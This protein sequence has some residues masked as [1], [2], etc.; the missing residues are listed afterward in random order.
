MY[1]TSPKHQKN[2]KL[3]Q[4]GTTNEGRPLLAIF[5]ASDENI[6]RLEEIRQNN[7]RLAGLVSTEGSGISTTTIPGT[8]KH[9]RYLLAK[10]QCTW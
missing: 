3:L 10:L 5:I 6:G 1:G 2:T 8:F 4:Y 9:T 7:L